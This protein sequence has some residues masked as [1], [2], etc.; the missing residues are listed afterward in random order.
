[1]L[2]EEK[3]SEIEIENRDEF[4]DGIFSQGSWA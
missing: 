1:M 4:F 2:N 3:G